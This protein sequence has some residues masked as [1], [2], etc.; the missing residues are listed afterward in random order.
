M[1]STNLYN[2]AYTI[3]EDGRVISHL[4]GTLERSCSAK[5]VL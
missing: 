2:G 1:K 3:Y 4:S 5:S